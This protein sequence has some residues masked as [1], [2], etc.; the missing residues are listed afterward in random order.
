MKMITTKMKLY[1]HKLITEPMKLKSGPTLKACR[2]NETSTKE[3][4]GDGR[5]V[6]S[7]MYVEK[8]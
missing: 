6:K 3:K 4:E 1:P 7:E 5:M 2:T 8:D